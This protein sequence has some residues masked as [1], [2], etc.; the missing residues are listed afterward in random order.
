MFLS[1]TLRKLNHSPKPICLKFSKDA[2]TSYPVKVLNIF[3]NF[4]RLK[5][6]LICPEQMHIF[7]VLNFLLCLYPSRTSW[8]DRSCQK[9]CSPP[10]KPNKRS[11]LNS[12]IA[13]YYKRFV[14]SLVPPL[15]NAFNSLL[16]QQ[17]LLIAI[18]MII[19]KPITDV[20][21]WSNYRHNP[22]PQ[23][24]CKTT[25][26]GPCDSPQYIGSS[27][28]TATLGHMSGMLATIQILSK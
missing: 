13:T 3:H 22:L 25:S 11:G 17:S 9:R 12:L 23:Y 4:M 5:G 15:T 10:S 24:R 18:I 7:L 21:V 8:S 26:K 16:D 27:L 2:Y 19:P 28:Y 1:L 6:T 20:S 14:D